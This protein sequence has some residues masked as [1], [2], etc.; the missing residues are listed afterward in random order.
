MSLDT[1]MAGSGRM[2]RGGQKRFSSGGF[3]SR[4]YRQQRGGAGMGGGGMGGP[5]SG[6]GGGPRSGYGGYG[7]STSRNQF[8]VE[9]Y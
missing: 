5:P 3:G 8:I 2:G 4:D 1:R 7:K 6:G 9:K